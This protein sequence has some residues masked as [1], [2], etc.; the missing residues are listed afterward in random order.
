[1]DNAQPEPS[2]EEILASIRRIISEDEEEQGAPAAKGDAAKAPALKKVEERPAPA[3]QKPDSAPQG[4][5]EVKETPQSDTEDLEMLKKNVAEEVQEAMMDQS[6][7]EAASDAFSTLSQTVRVSEGEGRTLEDIVIQML[8][9]MI[10]QW[11]DANLPALVEEK[12]EEE[13]QR[14]ARR[15][16]G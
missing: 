15:R 6:T 1:M 14:I 3:P 8:D 10:K 9:P 7:A 11:L 16:R 2:M 4:G 13:V 5:G 12:V